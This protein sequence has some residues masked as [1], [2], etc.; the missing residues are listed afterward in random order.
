MNFKSFLSKKKPESPVEKKLDVVN[1]V[2]FNDINLNSSIGDIETKMD[3]IVGKTVIFTT[4]KGYGRGDMTIKVSEVKVTFNKYAGDNDLKYNI[5]FNSHPI[6]TNSDIKILGKR[7][8][9]KED[10]LGEED[11][12][13]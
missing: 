10:P 8:L 12:D 3:S 13:E 6:D 2:S 4:H 11:W 1:V 9:S 5:R 7:I